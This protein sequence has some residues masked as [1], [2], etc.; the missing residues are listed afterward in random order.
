MRLA[1]TFLVQPLKS[2]K[3]YGRAFTCIRLRCTKQITR[4]CTDNYAILTLGI[5]GTY[6]ER[7][8]SFVLI[9]FFTLGQPASQ[10][11]NGARDGHVSVRVPTGELRRP[12][13]Q[14][15]VHLLH[16]RVHG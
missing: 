12:G 14:C 11:T 15:C 8:V 7:A 4:F 6:S 5:H 13:Q 3:R 9:L 16:L 2:T 10:P 1:K